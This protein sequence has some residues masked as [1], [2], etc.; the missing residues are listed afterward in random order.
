MHIKMNGS[1]VSANNGPDSLLPYSGIFEWS[2][3]RTFNADQHLRIAVHSC[4]V[5][6]KGHTK[7]KFLQDVIDIKV[8]STVIRRGV[9]ERYD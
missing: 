6:H 3:E 2:S 1:V 4:D 9:I 7:A 5:S 8:F